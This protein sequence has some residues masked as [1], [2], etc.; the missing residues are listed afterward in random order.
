MVSLRG[1]LKEWTSNDKQ[2]DSGDC[3]EDIADAQGNSRDAEEEK[4]ENR[5]NLGQDFAEDSEIVR[6]RAG[7]RRKGE[8][9]ESIA[10]KSVLSYFTRYVMWGGGTIRVSN[11]GISE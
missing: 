11:I 6:F 10:C 1:C 8:S 4:D 5:E 2:E 3:Q 9:E 7:A